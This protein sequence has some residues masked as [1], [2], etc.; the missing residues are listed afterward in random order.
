MLREINNI[1]QDSDDQ[2][3]RWFANEYFDL[4]VW[5]DDKGF[6]TGFQLCYGKNRNE[7]AITWKKLTGLTHARID[8]GER[9][10]SGNLA[11]IL[12]PDNKKIDPSVLDRFGNDALSIDPGVSLAVKDVL[13]YYIRNE[14]PPHL[15]GPVPLAGP[16]PRVD[17]FSKLAETLPPKPAPDATPGPTQV[18]APAGK[19]PVRSFADLARQIQPA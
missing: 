13:K 4:F 2:K 5:Q 9:D 10:V 3:T 6:V 16:K 15:K 12:V 8:T 11:P 18:P 17:F 19:H 1:K 7:E 14:Q